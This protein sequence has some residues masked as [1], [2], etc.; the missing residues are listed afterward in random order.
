MN[1]GGLNAGFA[2]SKVDMSQMNGKDTCDEQCNVRKNDEKR[3]QADA[4]SKL[5]S[6]MVNLNSAPYLLP[7]NDKSISF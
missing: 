5:Q 1:I 4:N 7:E 2:S 6:E 3:F